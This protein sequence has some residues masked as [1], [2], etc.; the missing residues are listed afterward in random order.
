M[1]KYEYLL[2]DADNT[3]L[4]FNEAERR[5]FRFTCEKCGLN[6]TDDLQEIYSEINLSLWKKLERGEVTMEFLKLER[7][8]LFLVRYDGEERDDT[9]DRAGEMKNTYMLALSEQGCTI[10]G[11]EELCA[12]LSKEYKMY[13]V[14]NGIA[15]IQRSRLALS[16][17]LPYFRGVF[18]S[19]EI[20][21]AKPSAGYF[22]HVIETIGERDL[23]KYLVIGDSLTS[24]CDGAI[25][26]GLDICRYNPNNSSNNG[27]DLTYNITKLSDLYDIL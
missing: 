3:L 11:A 6:Y 15:K 13:I 17:L 16:G 22:D 14:T 8:R 18:I 27:R 12:N 25:T 2:F 4:D 23:T 19:E 9:T 10:D 26:Y 21:H 5:A 1:K 20:G 7:F 24:D